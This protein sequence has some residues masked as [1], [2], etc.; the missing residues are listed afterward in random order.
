[1]TGDAMRQITF[2]CQPSFKKYSRPSRRERFLSSMDAMMP[3]SELEGWIEPYSLQA[4]RGRHLIGLGIM[5]RSTFC[6]NGSR[7]RIR[8]WKMR[9]MSHLCCA[10]L[11]G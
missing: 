11:P 1:M 5:L 9:C 2:A 3:W 6:S 7:Y 10:T 8:A 4:G